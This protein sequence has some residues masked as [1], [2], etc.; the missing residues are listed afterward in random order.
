MRDRKARRIKPARALPALARRQTPRPRR[1]TTPDAQ[2]RPRPGRACGGLRRK[3]W[4]HCDECGCD[5]QADPASRVRG[6]DCPACG[7][8]RTT[9]AVREH[10]RR[11]AP[12]RSLAVRRPNLAAELHPTLNPGVDATTLAAYSNRPLWWLCPICGNEWPAAPN[13]RHSA[14]RCKACRR[15]LGPRLT[16]PDSKPVA[17]S[18]S[19]SEKSRR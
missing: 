8:R 17:S 3:V 9:A 11:V 19:S 6:H 15:Y 13:A 2:R 10:R 5:W 12:E 16:P 4:W 18:P 14:G 1:A 7:R